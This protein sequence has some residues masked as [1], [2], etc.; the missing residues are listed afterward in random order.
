M[1]PDH[2]LRRLFNWSRA[3]R[4]PRAYGS[5]TSSS[6]AHALDAIALQRGIPPLDKDCAPLTPDEI[7]LAIDLQDAERLTRAYA[8]PYMSVKAKQLLRLK[9]GECRSDSACARKLRLGEKLFHKIHDEVCRKFQEVVETYF[10]P[11]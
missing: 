1:I 2:F 4:S 11:K 8:S 5:L 10:D 3:I 6:M 7:P 9:Y